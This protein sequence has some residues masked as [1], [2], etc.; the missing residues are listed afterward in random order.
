[1]QCVCTFSEWGNT[2]QKTL[3]ILSNSFSRTNQTEFSV[4]VG[5]H[6]NYSMHI[7]RIYDGC[8]QHFTHVT[9]AVNTD[10]IHTYI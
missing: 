9:L 6:D 7:S 4:L 2:I 5:K 1:M 8:P 10:N 3:V